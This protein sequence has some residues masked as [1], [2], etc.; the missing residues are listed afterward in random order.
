[1]DRQADP[2]H[3]WDLLMAAKD[4]PAIGSIIEVPD[5][6]KVTLPDGSVRMVVGGRYVVEHEGEHKIEKG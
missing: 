2:R 6:A 1:M 5:P 3:H 4:T